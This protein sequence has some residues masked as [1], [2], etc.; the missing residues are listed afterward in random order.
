METKIEKLICSQCGKDTTNDVCKEINGVI[1][2]AECSK[3][4]HKCTHCGDWHE[5]DELT[6][7][8]KLYYC[9]E[10]T[11]E[12]FFV[13]EYCGEWELQDKSTYVEDH[14]N[15]CES[16]VDSHHVQ[17]CPHCYNYYIEEDMTYVNSSD[18]FICFGCRDNLYYLCD[19]CNDYFRNGTDCNCSDSESDFLESYSYKPCPVFLKTEKQKHIKDIQEY[20][21]IELECEAKESRAD[22]IEDAI[23]LLNTD[24]YIYL[25]EDGSLDDK[26]GYEI[27]THPSTYEYHMDN[28]CAKVDRLREHSTSYKSGRCGIHIHVSRKHIG[29]NR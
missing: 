25:K 23:N 21:G 15:W 24:N 8:H 5:A 19:E 22:A 17:Q 26:K 29:E 13:C 4:W 14:G 3:N 6:E 1:F 9:Q 27:V 2:C 28:I 7:I 20:Y 11:D 18:M 12:L 10:C 16:C